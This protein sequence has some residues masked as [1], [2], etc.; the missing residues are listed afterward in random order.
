MSRAGVGG[1]VT[2]KVRCEVTSVSVFFD[3]D[4]VLADFVAGALKAHGRED[5]SAASVT[6]GIE[7][8]LRLEPAAFWAPLGFDFWAN[9]TPYPDGLSLLSAAIGMVGGD[10]IGLLTSPCD[11]AGCV[12]GKRAWVSRHL[13]QFSR[14]LFVGSAKELF[15][16][17]TK[18]LVDDHDANIDKFNRAGGRTLQPPRPWNRYGHNCRG[19]AF[20]VPSQIAMLA[21]EIGY[22]R[23]AA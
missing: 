23:S 5:V 8:Q 17:P 15:A 9:L 14:R 11:T 7:A 4:G 18:V 2:R 21:Q 3:L 19:A 20:D 1:D 6:W 10:N 16:G 13:P 22:A 12:D